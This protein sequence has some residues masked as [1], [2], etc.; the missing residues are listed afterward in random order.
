M[1]YLPTTTPTAGPVPFLFLPS[2]EE[3]GF[4]LRPPFLEEQ[5]QAAAVVVPRIMKY[6]CK[7][8]QK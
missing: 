7:T 6:Y 2:I 1:K 8:E 5:D 4:D 3:Y